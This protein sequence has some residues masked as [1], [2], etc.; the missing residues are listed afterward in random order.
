MT[1]RWLGATSASQ[2][3]GEMLATEQ[4]TSNLL[5][6]IRGWKG[7]VPPSSPLPRPLRR[8]KKKKTENTHGPFGGRRNGG[9]QTK[10]LYWCPLWEEFT[11]PP[12]PQ[13]SLGSGRG[14]G[15]YYS[16]LPF[17]CSSHTS[18]WIGVCE[19]EGVTGV[20]SSPKPTPSFLN[21][22]GSICD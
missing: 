3:K 20:L 14:E 8:Q 21:G 11:T 7:G 2:R 19:R 15:G 22:C 1:L 12:K 17:P 5:L 18:N 16:S 9:G 4:V 6:V 13:T 10:A